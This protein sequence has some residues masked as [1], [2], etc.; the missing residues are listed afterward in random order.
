[1]T[2]RI[3]TTAVL[4][5]VVLIGMKTHYR[6][7]RRRIWEQVP[8]AVRAA[9]ANQDGPIETPPLPENPV[10]FEEATLTSAAASVTHVAPVPGIDSAVVQPEYRN[11]SPLANTKA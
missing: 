3:G 1:M 10:G 11:T 2:F 5:V 6:S 8:A 4:I 7:Q 9:V